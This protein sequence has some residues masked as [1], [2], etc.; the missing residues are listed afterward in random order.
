MFTSTSVHANQNEFLGAFTTDTYPVDGCK[1]VKAWPAS[2]VI[3]YAS[4]SA[5]VDKEI[6]KKMGYVTTLDKKMWEHAIPIL[7]E[8]VEKLGANAIIGL[9]IVPATSYHGDQPENI[10][11][12]SRTAS[13]GYGIGVVLTMGTPVKV[14]CK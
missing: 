14:V 5:Y 1:I 8:D 9:E 10:S 6:D 2:A 4:G 13:Y 7:I 3:L 12:M 11:A